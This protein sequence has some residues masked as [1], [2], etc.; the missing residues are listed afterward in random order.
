MLNK[1]IKLME[2]FSGWPQSW[3]HRRR[4]LMVGMDPWAAGP[5]RW[6]ARGAMLPESPGEGGGVRAPTVWVRH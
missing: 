1:K 3:S 4:L 6:A 2:G 5:R